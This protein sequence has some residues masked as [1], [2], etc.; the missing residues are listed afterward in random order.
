VPI[1]I[2]YFTAWV[3]QDGT[4][5]FLHDVYGLD[6]NLEPER[7]RKLQHPA[8]AGRL[9]ADDRSAKGVR[10]DDRQKR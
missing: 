8:A 7:A 3:D 5:R 4:V 9:P 6:E 1:C 10:H 2:L